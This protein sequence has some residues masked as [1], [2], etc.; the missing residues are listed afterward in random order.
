MKRYPAIPRQ[1]AAIALCGG[2]AAAYYLACRKQVPGP[3][4]ARMRRHAACLM[5]LQHELVGVTPPAPRHLLL[6]QVCRSL[7]IRSSYAGPPAEL[8][9]ALV[10]ARFPLAFA[11]R[12]A[13]LNARIVD[14]PFVADED[15]GEAQLQVTCS[16]LSLL[17]RV[18]GGTMAWRRLAGDALCLEIW[19]EQ[20][21]WGCSVEVWVHV[22]PATDVAAAQLKLP[23]SPIVLAAAAAGAEGGAGA[24]A[25]SAAPAGA[26]GSPAAPATLTSP[27]PCTQPGSERQTCVCESGALIWGAWLPAT[28]CQWAGQHALGTACGHLGLQQ[29]TQAGEE[30][31]AV[32]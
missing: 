27:D 31:Y 18:V 25:S 13:A 6:L 16:L 8:M 22:L 12:L 11:S 15:S 30:S 5:P 9:R 2:A 32:G 26:G 7:R 1:W 3:Q 28:L 21:L 10:A 29:C 4:W 20:L 17:Q 23:L 19:L 24:A 14:V